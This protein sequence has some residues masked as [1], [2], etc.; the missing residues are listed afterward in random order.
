MRKREIEAKK[1]TG[2]K[3]YEINNILYDSYLSSF[4]TIGQIQI[5]ITR[6]F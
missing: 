1:R 6:L 4:S 5:Y 3:K 2:G